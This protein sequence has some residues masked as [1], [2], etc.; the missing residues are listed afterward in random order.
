MPRNIPS[1]LSIVAVETLQKL[2]YALL[3]WISD[4][5]ACFFN[6]L[7]NDICVKSLFAAPHTT[8]AL[9]FRSA[10]LLFPLSPLVSPVY[11]F[12]FYFF[13]TFA[14]SLSNISHGL[15]CSGVRARSFY[16]NNN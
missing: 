11:L 6:T 13:L 12:C 10:L 3:W 15:C 16:G 5:F 14:H 9:S 4:A 7:H 2:F 1:K 8:F